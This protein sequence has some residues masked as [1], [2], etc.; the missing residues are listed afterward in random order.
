MS[1]LMNWLEPQEQ[2]ETREEQLRKQINA[3]SDTERKAFYH[4]QSKLIKDPDNYAVLNYFFLGGVHHLYLGRY[5]RFI[6]ELVL[7]IIAILSFILGGSGLGVLILIALCGYELPQLFL[8][9]KIV[10][11]YNEAIS[12]E[13]YEQIIHSGSPHRDH[14]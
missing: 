9:Q 13:L 3:L 11:Q 1:S 7:L 5:K 14:H 6:A 2:L 8:S 12:R 10:R 4:E